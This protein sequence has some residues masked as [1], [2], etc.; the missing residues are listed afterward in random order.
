M[1]PRTTLNLVGVLLTM[2]SY[3]ATVLYRKVR[4]LFLPHRVWVLEIYL[5]CLSF[6]IRGMLEYWD[7]RHVVAAW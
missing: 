4:I 3:L 2:Q 5:P 6:R 7:S 1:D